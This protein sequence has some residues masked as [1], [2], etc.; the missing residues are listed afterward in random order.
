[1]A[2]NTLYKQAAVDFL[3]LVV[4][5]KID[6]AYAKHVNMGGKHH[7]P[8]FAA[9]FPAL[10]QAMIDDQAQSPNKRMS[11]K[12]VL[13]DGDTVAVHSHIVSQIGDPGF[14]TVHIFRFQ[15]DKI[16]ELW[17]I[18]QAVPAD[19]PNQDGAFG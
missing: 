12:N 18:G 7:N 4:A 14:A 1:M 2:D 8:F 15:D 3:Q 17:D 13:S 6:E 5:G 9:G 11:V 10:K 19:S 16:V